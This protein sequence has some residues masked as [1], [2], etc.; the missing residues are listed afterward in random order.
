MAWNLLLMEKLENQI[1]Y[2]QIISMYLTA[3][4]CRSVVMCMKGD[5]LSH[6]CYGIECD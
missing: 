1:L 3:S 5:L 4:L 6:K 2:V